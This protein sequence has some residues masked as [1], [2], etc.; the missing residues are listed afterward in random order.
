MASILLI[1]DDKRLTSV[2]PRVLKRSGHSVVVARD[3]NEALTE[4]KGQTAFVLAI[5]DVMLPLADAFDDGVGGL[6]AGIEIVRRIREDPALGHRREMKLLAYTVRGVTPH[7]KAA[8][9]AL[10]A[11]VLTKGGDPRSVLDEIERLTSRG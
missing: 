6:E 2:M 3:A 7:I 1:E 9:E 4:L 8:L 11:V 5:V 10:G